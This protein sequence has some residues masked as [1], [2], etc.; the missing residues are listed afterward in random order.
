M[1]RL[2]PYLGGKRLLTKTILALI[3]AHRLYCEPF[4]GSATIL[5]AKPPSPCEVLNDLNGDLVNLFRIVQHHP[6]EFLKCLRWILYS[7][8]EFT[9]QRDSQPYTLTDIQRAVR[10]FYIF[11]CGF[12]GMGRHFGI[13]RNRKIKG[14][15]AKAVSSLIKEI[16]ERLEKVILE[17]LP[18]G[19]CLRLYDGPETFFYL[20]PPYWGHEKDYGP[21]IF[22]PEDFITLAA[23]LQGLQGRFLMSLNDTPEV[24]EIFQGH[25]MQEVA[26]TYSAGTGGPGGA[27]RPAKKAK[28][29]LIAN[30]L[31]KNMPK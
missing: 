27:G 28:E 20:D 17:S 2:I 15:S 5:L 12:G 31:L 30:Y 1:S 22:S 4:A 11:R 13:C 21:G 10:F 3:P 6:E 16:H 19:E 23:L 29:L 7:R 25:Q 14:I 18:Y 26:T 24:R 9:R 8:A